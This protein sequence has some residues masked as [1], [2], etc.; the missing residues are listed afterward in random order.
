M[1]TKLT[2][3]ADIVKDDN[4]KHLIESVSDAF[5][6]LIPDLVGGEVRRDSSEQLM[7]VSVFHQVNNGAEHIA[8]IQDLGWLLAKV[9]DGEHGA[10]SQA[11]Y[12]IEVFRHDYD[13]H[14]IDNPHPDSKV[15][16]EEL[17]M[18]TPVEI[19][20]GTLQ[21]IHERGL[22]VAAG[23]AEHHAEFRFLTGEVFGEIFEVSL[24]VFVEYWSSITALH[25]R[26]VMRS[27]QVQSVSFRHV[28]P[29]TIHRN[30]LPCDL[31]HQ[32]LDALHIYLRIRRLLRVL[33][34]VFLSH[35]L[36]FFSDE[37]L[38]S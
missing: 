24:R 35:F 36:C 6:V 2:P 11:S 32:S 14:G 19:V 31:R 20:D 17:E 28:E 15:L 10:L 13:V 1:G 3:V 23:A 7:L 16:T 30:L 22:A 5:A 25:N 18:A 38:P 21:G 27:Q 33:I 8:V 9:I 26:T 4:L 12:R 37:F 34:F 29:K